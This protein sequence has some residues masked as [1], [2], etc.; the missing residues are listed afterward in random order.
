MR[1]HSADSA[2]VGL[3]RMILS[4]RTEPTDAARWWQVFDDPVLDAPGRARLRAE[5]DAAGRGSA[6]P[7][8]AGA[9]RHRDRRPLPAE[10]GSSAARTRATRS[11]RTRP[12]RVSA[13]A[14]STTGR[15]ASTRAGSSTSGAS[16]AAASRPPTPSCSPRSPTTT[17]CWSAWSA[18]SPPTYV[19]IRVLEERLALARDN[20]RRAAR[21]PEHRARALRGRRHLRPRR[22]AGDDAAA[23]HRGDDPAARDPAAAERTTRS[24]CCSA[25]RRRDLDRVLGSVGRHPGAAADGRGRHPRRA[26]ASAGPT[27]AAPSGSSRRRARASAS[28]SPICFPR[29]QL[30]GSVGLSADRRRS[31]SRAARS[32]RS[33]GPQFNW[34]I[35]NYGRLINDVRVAGRDVPGA[36]RQLR[37]HRAA[38]AAGRRGRAGRLPARHRAGGAPRAKRRRRRTAPSSSRSSSTARAPPTTRACSP[39]SRRSSA[40]TIA[41]CR[42]AAPSRSSVIALYKALGGGWEIRDGND[43]VPAAT[44]EEMRAHGTGAVSMLERSAT[45][46][47]DEARPTPSTTL[48][49]WRWWWPEW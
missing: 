44:Q 5:P 49:A 26:A 19:Q 7:R 42:R 32:R 23:R 1:A 30:T 22:A 25:C 43:F 45:S 16:S 17:T 38:R 21:Q 12:R 13:A 47:I 10:A 40:R 33:A 11:A 37:Q 24:A 2:T 41:R 8:G 4:V 31:S 27:C 6:R 39:R 34:P 3:S 28:P 46:E 15:P 14:T 9:A 48:V 35:L 29:I 20:V 18:R 36:R